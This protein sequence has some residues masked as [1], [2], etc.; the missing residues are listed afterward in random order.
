MVGLF[1]FYR[2]AS[3]YFTDTM[4]MLCCRA[5]ACYSTSVTYDLLSLDQQIQKLGIDTIVAAFHVITNEQP[6]LC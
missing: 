6:G 3:C 4:Q 2:G 1:G 5:T